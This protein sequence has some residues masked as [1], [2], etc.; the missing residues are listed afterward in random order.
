MIPGPRAKF[1]QDASN[2]PLLDLFQMDLWPQYHDNLSNTP[3]RAPDQAKQRAR[4]SRR[5][6]EV[7][8]AWSII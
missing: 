1:I 7:K 3:K 4:H 6:E 8:N 2:H 5:R